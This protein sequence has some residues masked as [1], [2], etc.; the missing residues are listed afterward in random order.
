[1]PADGTDSLKTSGAVGS[2][3]SA[4][5]HLLA[6]SRAATVM[7]FKPLPNAWTY[8][9]DWTVPACD[10]GE[11]A[12][13]GAVMSQIKC[14]FSVLC[15]LQPCCLRLSTVRTTT[16]TDCYYLFL[17][18]DAEFTRETIMFGEAALQLLN[19]YMA[20][21][22]GYETENQNRQSRRRASHT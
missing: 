21:R 22:K 20:P 15:Y 14:M 18:L 1:M 11:G 19:V 2:T 6:M 12:R 9:V 5:F 10:D 16:S 8:E 4:S 7:W 17:R 3:G 13:H